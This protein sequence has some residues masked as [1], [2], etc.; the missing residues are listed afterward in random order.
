MAI[1]FAFALHQQCIQC[2]DAKDDQME[3]E[4]GQDDQNY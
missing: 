3:T 4:I 1:A 2:I